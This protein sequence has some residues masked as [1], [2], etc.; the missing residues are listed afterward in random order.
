MSDRSS[1][2]TQAIKKAS[3]NEPF[4]RA[5]IVFGTIFL[6]ASVVIWIG[7]L[8]NYLSF[9][10]FAY[11]FFAI[12]MLMLHFGLV[13]YQGDTES[14][15]FIWQSNALSMIGVISIPFGFSSWIFL[16][17]G[18]F[19]AFFAYFILKIPEARNT[20]YIWG[21]VLIGLGAYLSNFSTPISHFISTG[22]QI[23]GFAFIGMTVYR[24]RQTEEYKVRTK[25]DYYSFII[26]SGWAFFLILSIFPWFLFFHKA[27]Y[28]ISW[29]LE[30]LALLYSVT[31]IYSGLWLIKTPKWIIN[32]SKE[33]SNSG[34]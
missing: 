23:V 9:L 19:M 8:L 2:F 26:L 32:F 16:I 18:L 12:S 14:K 15:M 25:F 7:T 17:P 33:D 28:G 11:I 6:V 29:L 22:T 4:S 13:V 10:G 20:Q 31:Q 24:V 27:Y 34:K 3:G 1:P 30:G 5:L 21:N